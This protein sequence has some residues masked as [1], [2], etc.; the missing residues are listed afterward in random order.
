LGGKKPELPEFSYAA[1]RQRAEVDPAMRR[2]ALAACGIS[3]LVIALALFW[4]GV[5]P[6]V[7]FGP[8]P[9]IA[10]PATPLRVAP[11]DPG[12]LTV[13]GANVQI[14]S[15]A[16]SSAPAQLAPAVQAPQV[17]ALDQSAGIVAPAAPAP[18]PVAATSGPA[19]V[20]LGSAVDQAGVAKIWS[21]LESTVPGLLTGKAPEYVPAVV[22]GQNIVRLMVGGFAD[23]PTARAFC[24]ALVAK[25]DTCRV[26]GF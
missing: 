2:I 10:A 18:P 1:R 3:V 19:Q 24:A 6:R 26:A 21:Q 8:P 20:Q 23:A 12:G 7:G 17:A 16:A 5:R 9:E 22:D 13:P 14:M 25:G 11:A 15:G 4:S